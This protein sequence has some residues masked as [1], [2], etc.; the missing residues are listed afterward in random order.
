MVD[1]EDHCGKKVA[2]NL[3]YSNDV[4]SGKLPPLSYT[5]VR[6]MLK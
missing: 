3:K 2:L 5:Q 6:V 4:F 1:T